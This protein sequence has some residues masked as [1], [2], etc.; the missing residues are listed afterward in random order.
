MKQLI[1]KL[2]VTLPCVLIFLFGFFAINIQAQNDAR[3]L[4]ENLEEEELK[5]IDALAMYPEDTR[6]AILQTTLHP[7]ALIKIQRIQSKTKDG[8][9]NL[10]NQYPQETQQEV[11]D[12]TRYPKLIHHLLNEVNRNTKSIDN[13]L[14]D[15]PKAIHARA[16][17]SLKNHYDLLK[18]VDVLGKTNEIA[19]NN[20]LEKYDSETQNAFRHLVELPEVMT[21]LTENIEV[22][23]L[24]GDAYKN[25]PDWIIRKTDSLN[26]E[27]ARQNVKELEDWKKRVEENPEVVEE[28][29]A[30]VKDFSKENGY[31]DLYYDAEESEYPYDDIYYEEEEEES[32]VIEKYYHYNYPY[33]YGYPSW[34]AYPRWHPYPY[35]YDWGFRNRRGRSIVIIHMPSYYF[36]DWYFYRPHHHHH[37]PH[38][39]AHFVDHYYGHRHSVGS[40]TSSVHHWRNR[41]REVISDDMISNAPSRIK[42]FKEFGK[43]ETARIS[44]NKSNPKAPLTQKKYVEKN[45]KSYPILEKDLSRNDKVTSKGDPRVSPKKKEVTPKYKFPTTKEKTRTPKI[46][47]Q[48]TDSRFKKPKT[49]KKAKDYHQKTWEKSKRKTTILRKT[50][51]PRTKVKTNTS[52]K[53]ST[54]TTKPRK[55]TK[56]D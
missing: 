14:S 35:W 2:A 39:S 8:F 6:L 25:Y 41:N 4:L 7:E 37:Y 20:V 46:P 55:K 23:I 11:W 17:K 12:L 13:I 34:Y 21:I 16:K 36:V 48:K 24:V 56:N 44:Y 9:T 45:K 30:S 49:S 1:S 33:W 43:M 19:F 53:K 15:Y 47:R 38:L 27:L 54:K 31:D 3:V 51:T 52:R 29:E 28:L 18:E 26:L 40:I 5:N 32:V 10:M 42:E 50:T 22:T